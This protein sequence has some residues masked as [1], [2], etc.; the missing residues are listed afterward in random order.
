MRVY[1]KFLSIFKHYDR[2]ILIGE[3]FVGM[4][5]LFLITVRGQVVLVIDHY[6]NLFSDIL[7]H[8]IL[9]THV[10]LLNT[11]INVYCG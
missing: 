2:E 1:G 11:T 5:K 6:G 4:K 10:N 9:M 8:S 3:Y 7:I